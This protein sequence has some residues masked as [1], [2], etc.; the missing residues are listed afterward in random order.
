MKEWMKETKWKSK[1]DCGVC[2]WNTSS[3]TQLT[4]TV[5]SPYNIKSDFIIN[6]ENDTKTKLHEIIVEPYNLFFR[7]LRLT[8]CKKWFLRYMASFYPS[9]TWKN[10]KEGLPE[11]KVKNPMANFNHRYAR[12]RLCRRRLSRKSRKASGGKSTHFL[13]VL[14]KSLK[15]GYD[16]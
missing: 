13:Y 15:I 10:N 6:E 16:Q 8:C 12:S 11:G 7:S 4:Y 14:F 9:T 1:E 5:W 3:H 2:T